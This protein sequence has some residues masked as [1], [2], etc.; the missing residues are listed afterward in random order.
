MTKMTSNDIKHNLQEITDN[1]EQIDSYIS[2][3]ESYGDVEFDENDVDALYDDF[4]LYFDH[5]DFWKNH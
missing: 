1:S 5:K 4:E 3:Y 2:D